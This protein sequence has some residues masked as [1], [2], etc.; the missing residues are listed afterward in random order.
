MREMKEWLQ[1]RTRLK[2]MMRRRRMM[3]LYNMRI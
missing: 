3:A 2:M 1:L